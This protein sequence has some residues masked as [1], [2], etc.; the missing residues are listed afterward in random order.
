[1]QLLK[2]I[3]LTSFISVSATTWAQLKP[4]YSATN[5]KYGYQNES[6]QEIVPARYDLAYSFI[7][8]RA[9]VKVNGK[10]GYLDES[11]KEIVP[12]QYD[13]TWHFIGGYAAVRVGDKFGF[14]DKSGKEVV[15][16]QYEDANNYHGN[17]CYKGMAHV[18]E[19][20][21]WKIIR[22]ADGKAVSQ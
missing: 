22:L 9:A 21:E 13:F 12:P 15:T 16:P 17:C 11:G 2:L 4:V 20:G 8:G 5:S 14:I 1:M 10:Y 3:I 7:D 19:K 6:G 18:K